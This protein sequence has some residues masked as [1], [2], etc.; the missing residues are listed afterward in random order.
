MWEVD[1]LEFRTIHPSLQLIRV[2]EAATT[3]GQHPMRDR[4]AARVLVDC[5]AADSA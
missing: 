1:P 4:V 2:K 3:M 5:P